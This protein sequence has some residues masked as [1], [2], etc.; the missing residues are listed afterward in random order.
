MIR[1]KKAL[2]NNVVLAED[3]ESEKI[4]FGTGIGFKKRKGDEVDEALIIKEFSQV[5][6]IVGHYNLNEFSPDV[7]DICFK[8]LKQGEIDLQQD[9][10]VG[11]F[12]SLLDHIHFAINNRQLNDNPIQYEIPHLYIKEYHMGKRS[13]EMIKE[14]L[15]VSLPEQEA[16]FIALHFVNGAIEQ[17]TINETIHHTEIIKEIIKIIQT[18]FEVSLDKTSLEYSRFITHLRY[19]ITRQSKRHSIDID[20]DISQLIQTKYLKSYACSLL[21]K[22]YLERECHWNVQDDELVYLTIH[23]EK[24]RKTM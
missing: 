21:I 11:T 8:I 13:L 3:G 10:G 4:V 6:P 2:N 16:A 1:V 15:G 12:F 9:F 19:F 23:I 5:S 17:S 7:V 22:H 14:A 18:I 20:Q 24:I